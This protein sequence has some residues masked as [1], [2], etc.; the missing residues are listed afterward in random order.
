MV[1]QGHL[2]CGLKHEHIQQHLLSEGDTLI[3]GKPIDRAQA[4]ESAIKQWSLIHS[5][6]GVEKHLEN[7]HKV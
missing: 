2:V 6:Q 4:T 1:L 7:I 3:L 5:T